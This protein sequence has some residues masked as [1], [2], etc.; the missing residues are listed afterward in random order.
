MGDTIIKSWLETHLDRLEKPTMSLHRS[1]DLYIK[2]NGGPIK[3]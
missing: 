3:Y 2:A 1:M